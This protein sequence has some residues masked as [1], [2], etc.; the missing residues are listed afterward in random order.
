MRIPIVKIGGKHNKSFFT[1]YAAEE[2]I[3]KI[4]ALNDQLK[5]SRKSASDNKLLSDNLKFLGTRVYGPVPKE[6]RVGK[7]ESLYRKIIS[8]S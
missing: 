7:K 4:Q 2:Y 1:Q 8:Y 3:K 5:N 6:I